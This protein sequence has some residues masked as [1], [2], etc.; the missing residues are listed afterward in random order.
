MKASIW[1]ITRGFL[2]CSAISLV[3]SVTPPRTK[4]CEPV[5]A[6]RLPDFRWNTIALACRY[7][8]LRYSVWCRVIAI[9]AAIRMR[10]KWL[11]LRGGLNHISW[12]LD[13]MTLPNSPVGQYWDTN[14]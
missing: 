2:V 10:L 9:D 4:L 1:S 3:P 13:A 14:T 12:G 5:I 8:R 6:T 11:A 7:W